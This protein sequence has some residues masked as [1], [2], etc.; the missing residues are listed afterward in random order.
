MSTELQSEHLEYVLRSPYEYSYVLV[1][2]PVLWTIDF[3]FLLDGSSFL[4]LLS[5]NLGMPA[6]RSTEDSCVT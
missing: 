1:R 4:F 5:L 6:G 3:T 2:Y